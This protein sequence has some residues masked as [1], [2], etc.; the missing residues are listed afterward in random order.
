MSKLAIISS[1]PA[2][3]FAG[4]AN[5]ESFWFTQAESR[6]A[7]KDERQVFID[8]IWIPDLEKKVQI[9]IIRAMD[10]IP[11]DYS[12]DAYILW[13]S[14]AMVTEREQ[15]E[16]INRLIKFVEWEVWKWKPILGL[17]FGHQIL[18]TALGWKVE[19]MQD[20]KIGRWQ[21]ETGGN[22]MDALWSHKQ[23]VIDAWSGII[24]G[25]WLW[26][27][28]TNSVIQMI[29]YENATGM[30]LHPEFSPEFTSFLV[31]LMRQQITSEW[32]DVEEILKQIESMNGE[33]PS[34]VLLEGFVRKYYNL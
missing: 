30:Q 29:Q 9:E 5:N 3:A 33:N 18:A 14:P 27:M 8:A 17:C 20:R 19:P 25:T 10:G 34:R 12:A 7:L 13:G 28:G 26:W 24:T 31:K 6:S 21:F 15:K 23:G 32:L 2:W 11:A 1:V 4:I 22:N 16:W